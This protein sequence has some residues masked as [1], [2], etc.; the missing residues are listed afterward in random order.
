MTYTF[1]VSFQLKQNHSDFAYIELDDEQADR[2]IALVRDPSSTLRDKM[3]A[4][5]PELLSDHIFKTAREWFVMERIDND[6]VEQELLDEASHSVDLESM[7][8]VYYLMDND[9]FWNSVSFDP[10]AAITDIE[11]LDTIHAHRVTNRTD[12]KYLP[13]LLKDVI[14]ACGYFY[15]FPRDIVIEDYDLD[16]VYLSCGTDNNDKYH[17]RTWNI[18]ENEDNNELRI[19]WTLFRNRGESQGAERIAGDTTL[20]RV[21][22]IDKDRKERN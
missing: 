5:T 12:N 9:K 17:I 4:F 1:H 6:E 7:D 22:D 19:E 8:L 10:K 11:Y 15:M 20:L 16:D 14:R 13:A 18:E 3:A 21:S 2:I